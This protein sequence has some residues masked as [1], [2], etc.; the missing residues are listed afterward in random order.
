M[1]LHLNYRKRRPCLISFSGVDCS[2]KSTQISAVIDRMRQLGERPFYIWLRVGYTPLFSA[3][4]DVMRRLLGHQRLPQGQSKQR[5][6]FMSTGWKRSLWLHLAFA[7]IA[8]QTAVRVRLLRLLG[9]NVLCDRYIEESE[10]DLR[11]NFDDHTAQLLA[12][13][14]VKA[15]AARPDI[16]IFLDLP[17]DESLRRSILKNEP[18]P[19]SEE[20]RRRRAAL[21]ET[22]KVEGGYC[23][24]DARMSINEISATIDS[25]LLGDG[26]LFER[27][28]EVPS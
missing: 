22:L 17:F 12:W 7:D 27:A 5:D 26:V 11:L 21:Y 9:Y 23:I 14:L 18:F 10:V 13:R 2:G 25:F 28:H 24:V 19:D 8:F 4:K 3:L 15:I 16:R 20:R 6:R 1:A